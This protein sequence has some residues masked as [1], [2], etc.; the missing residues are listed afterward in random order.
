MGDWVR[1]IAEA[2][3][4]IEEPE[5]HDESKHEPASEAKVVLGDAPP[6]SG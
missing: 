6:A 5:L 4:L 1:R 3:T 2:F